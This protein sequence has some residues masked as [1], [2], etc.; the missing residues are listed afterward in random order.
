MMAV[1]GTRATGRHA[2]GKPRPHV[3]VSG[4]DPVVH[5]KYLTWLQQR[6]QAN[7]RKEEWDLT[8]EQ[9]CGLWGD[10][11]VQRGRGSDQYCMTRED[12]DGPWDNKNT[13]VIL[14]KEQLQRHKARQMALGQT[15]GY[16]NKLIA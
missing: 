5:K 6:N 8:F 9:W 16:K 15:R 10:L 14:R 11:W 2:A 3:W 7:F 13:I 4:P 12:L 1:K